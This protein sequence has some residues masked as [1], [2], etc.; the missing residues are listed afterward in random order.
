MGN[1]TP[2]ER[3]IRYVECMCGDSS[4]VTRFVWWRWETD[5]YKNGKKV[6]DPDP[7]YD[8]ISV[9]TQM[10]LQWPWY[11]RVW[12]A[13]KYVF[14]MQCRYGHWHEA[15]FGESEVKKIIEVCQEYVQHIEDKEK[16]YE[17]ST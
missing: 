6:E 2:E 4:H 10:N 7:F 14:G 8:E 12:L 3:P 16:R 9:E 13:V 15:S 1:W 17:K 5:T 11:K